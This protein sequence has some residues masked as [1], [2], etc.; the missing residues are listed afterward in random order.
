MTDF[1]PL[2][3][4]IAL[5]AGATRGA[6]RG[7]AC[8]LGKAGAT[9]YCTGRSVRGKPAGDRPETIEGTA[10]RV[11]AL[12]GHGIAVQV[13]HTQEA[14][15]VSL[16]ER[17]RSEQGRIDI[18]VNDIWGGDELTEWGKPFWELDVKKG[19][20]LIERALHTHIL[21]A[22]HGVPLMLGHPGGLVVEIT[23][24]D[25]IVNRHYRGNLF[26]DLVKT[27]VMRLAFGMAQELR[28]HHIAAVALSPGFLRSEA[29]L[30]LFGVTEESWRD[31]IE[32]DPSFAESES[33]WLVGRAVAALAADPFVLAKSGQSFATWTLAKEYGL[34]D[35]DGRRPDMGTVLEEG[36]AERFEAVV[37][38]VGERLRADGLDPER[39]LQ[40]DADRLAILGRVERAGEAAWLPWCAGHVDVW[41]SEPGDLAK[42]FVA[43]WRS[44]GEQG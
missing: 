21:T 39:V 3:G 31:A 43:W 34:T 30:E 1:T 22:R 7:I 25:S 2:S 35:A 10:E 24:G 33:P 44:A 18:L 26:Y 4:K 38:A 17:I 16:M 6:G 29:V 14:Q 12:G 27:T 23:D 41:F 40:I 20:Q 19:F 32:K 15:V 11:T 28:D 13:D 5:V 36:T 9:V 42:S 37:E 8:M